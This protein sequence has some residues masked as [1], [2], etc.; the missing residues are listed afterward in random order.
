[1]SAVQISATFFLPKNSIGTMSKFCRKNVYNRIKIG[2]MN[3]GIFS[4]SSIP[5]FEL[6][7]TH[8]VGHSR[9]SD[10]ICTYQLNMDSLKPV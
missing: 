4:N 8:K 10:M 1:M 7:I 2:Q 5:I 9:K 3:E 6:E